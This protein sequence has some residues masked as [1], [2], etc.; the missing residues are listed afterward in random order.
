M[1]TYGSP[2]APN[3]KTVYFDALFSQSLAADAKRLHDNIGASNPF[4]YEIMK[5]DLYQGEDGGTNIEIQLMYQLAS[6]DWYS[7]YDELPTTPIDGV[8]KALY[9]WAQ[10]A[11]PVAY[12]MKEVKQNKKKLIDLVDTKMTQAELGFQEGFSQALM[13]G[14]K[15]AGGNLITVPTSSVNGASGINPLPLLIAY[16]PTASVTIGGLNQNTYSWWRNKTKTSAATTYDG[17]ILEFNQIFNSSALGTGGE[18]KLVSLDQVSYELFVHAYWIHYRKT[19]DSDANYPFTN[20]IFRQARVV[21]D[22]KVP[23][24]YSDATAATTYGSAF[25]INPTFFKVKYDND[26]NFSMLKDEN[27]K[28]FQ[29]PV[30]Q[31]ARVGHMAWMG[32]TCVSNRRK[33]GVLGKIARTLTA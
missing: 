24:V 8:T 17:L 11:V 16:D 1:P 20:S 9:D 22:E 21:M 30:N 15:P 6:M 4:F 33:Q 28:T 25:F 19:M 31:D 26:S 7:A 12:H 32:Q 10:A 29:K 13:W 3:S 14:G 27:G 5:R 2:S 23:D 18:P